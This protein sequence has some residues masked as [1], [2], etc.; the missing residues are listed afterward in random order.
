M[1]YTSNFD[2]QVLLEQVV[3]VVFELVVE[4]RAPLAALSLATFF[5]AAFLAFDVGVF[6]EVLQLVCVLGLV[7]EEIPRVSL[8]NGRRGTIR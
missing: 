7:C 8:T 6:D 4:F 2:T 3:V 5:I 1:T